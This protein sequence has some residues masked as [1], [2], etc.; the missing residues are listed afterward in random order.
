MRYQKPKGTADIIS[1]VSQVW[2][3]VEKVADQIFSNYNYSEIRTPLFEN[4]EL[5]SRS[6][7]ETSD[8]VSKEMYDFEDKGG[9]H[10]SLRPE[11]T[12]G[13]VRAFVEQKLYGPEHIKPVR[14]HY[15][16]SMFRYER[17][18]AGRMREFHQLGV[19]AFGI[20]SVQLDVEQICMALDF[21]QNLGIKNLKLVINTLGDQDS[22][23]NYRK[24][25]IEY[26]KPH[27]DELSEDSKTRFEKNPLRILDSKNSKDQELISDAPKIVD[28][29][30]SD[31]KLKFDQLKHQLNDLNIEYVVD[32]N[33]VRG[34]DY[35]NYTIFEIMTQDDRLGTGF[36][37][38]CA[39]GRYNNLV[40]ELGGPECPGVGFAIGLER[41]ILLLSQS[42]FSKV[43]DKSLDVYVIGI[44]D[45]AQIK[46]QEI[47]HKLRQQGFK[48]D[49]NYLDKKLKSL[50]KVAD[51]L[52]AKLVITIGEA[53]LVDSSFNLKNMQT[54]TEEKVALNDLEKVVLKTLKDNN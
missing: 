22:R 18:Q 42:E 41:L 2:S 7:G 34:L 6:T 49:Q 54:G 37:T 30:N 10:I 36:T 5:F 20:D 35:Y 25:L 46:S 26:L 38:I 21:F 50:F 27:F 48:I 12:A 32:S 47:V 14:V 3:R 28:Y 13:V 16:G 44:G 52:Q 17:P 4:F 11:G 33:M 51:K 23:N 39:G 24:A 40:E 53:E 43:E 9:R 8:I 45:K 31:S 19:E 29:L 1:P 15:K